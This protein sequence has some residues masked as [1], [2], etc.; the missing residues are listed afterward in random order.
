MGVSYKFM[1]AVPGLRPG[2][3]GAFHSR[4][5]RVRCIMCAR[6]EVNGG[7]ARKDFLSDVIAY[8]RHPLR[9]L[10]LSGPGRPSRWA[11]LVLRAPFL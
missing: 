3:G 1:P 9:F 7:G 10:L 8:K 4:K 5:E 11:L 2:C 6:Q